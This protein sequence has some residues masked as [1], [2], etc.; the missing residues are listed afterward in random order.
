MI[1]YNFWF[2]Y[3]LFLII[4]GGILIL[5]IYITRVASDEKFKFSIKIIIFF[6]IIFLSFISFII[7][8]LPH[9]S[10]NNK[11]L[12]LRDSARDIGVELS[13]NKILNLPS[14]ILFIILIIYLF[15][16]IIAIVK[17]TNIKSGP[18][19]QKF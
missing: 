15:I 6:T 16:T 1:N 14:N 8:N 11:I 5:F 12:K 10:I 17:I 19:R 4:V 7:R 18:L 13:I 3:I 2:S 9:L